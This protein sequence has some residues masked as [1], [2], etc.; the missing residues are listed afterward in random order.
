MKSDE[1][2]LLRSFFREMHPTLEV[3]P[4]LDLLESGALDS[5]GIVELMAFIEE[6]FGISLD[7]AAITASNFRTMNAVL[8]LIRSHEK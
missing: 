2:Q 5:L 3:D 4:E 7:P 8:S 1:T 6:K